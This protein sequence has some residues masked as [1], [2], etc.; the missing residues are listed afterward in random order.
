MSVKRRGAGWQIDFKKPDGTRYRKI[1]PARSEDEAL[2]IEQKL[3][4]DFRLGRAPT[5]GI[6]LREAC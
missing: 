6:T 1:H 5:G 4:R 3:R 2:F